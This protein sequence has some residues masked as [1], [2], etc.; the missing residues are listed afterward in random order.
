MAKIFDLSTGKEKFTSNPNSLPENDINEESDNQNHEL[1]NNERQ[2][3]IIATL[4]NLHALTITTLNENQFIRLRLLKE[5]MEKLSGEI[6]KN[7]YSEYV[8]M[9]KTQ[10]IED[11]LPILDNLTDHDFK[12][13]PAYAKALINVLEEKDYS[14]SMAKRKK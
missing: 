3:Y 1:A 14:E 10:S 4:R 7:A 13:R 11:L 5:K 12:S 8:S 2:K 9:F 6:S